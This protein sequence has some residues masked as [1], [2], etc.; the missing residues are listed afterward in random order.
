[1]NPI[2]FPT[3]ETQESARRSR[4]WPRARI[5]LIGFVLAVLVPAAADAAAPDTT[6]HDVIVRPVDN[7]KLTRLPVER[8]RWATAANDLGAVPP[9]LPLGRL[10]LALRRS[11]DRQLAYE[12]FLREQQDPTSANYRHWLTPSEIG[13]RFGASQHDIDLLSGWLQT[14]GLK[15]DAVANNRLRIHFSGRADKVTAAFATELHY[16]QAG[17]EKRMANTT[18]P[19]LPVALADAVRS[20]QGLSAIRFKPLSRVETRRQAAAMPG[21][22]AQPQGT[23]CSG[24]ACTHAIFPADFARIFDLAP[25]QQQ[26]VDGSGQTIAIVGRARVNAPDIENF[27]SLAGLARKQPTVLIPTGG[28]DPGAPATTCSDS[29]T[30]SCS[31]PTDAVKDQGEATLDVQRAGSVAPGAT[32]D[33]IVSADTRSIDGVS[34]AIQY[35]IDTD[36][37]P[38]KILSISFG[39]CEADNSADNAAYIDELFGQAAMEGISVFVASGDGGVAGCAGIDSTPTPNERVSANLLCASGNATCVGGTQFADSVNPAAFWSSSN[40]AGYESALGYIPEGSW[41]EALSR[42]GTP[43]MA[44]SGGGVS[45]YIAT[46]PWQVGIGVPGRQGR[47]TP[48]VSFPAATSEGYFG[49]TAA[50]GGACVVTNQGFNFLSG[51]GTS[52][53]TPSMAGIAALLNQKTGTA[54]ANLNPRLYALAANPANRVFHDATP[55]SSGVANCSVAIPSLCNNSTPG[56]DGVGGGLA[57]YALE[58]GYDRATGLGSIDV[59]NLLA[60]WNV[61]QTVAVNL[62]QRGVSGTWANP[63]TDGQGFVMEVAPDF[64]GS[65]TGFLF[66]GWY[67]YDATAGQRWYTLQ[68]QVGT[69]ASAAIPIYLTQ[70][71]QFD[72][73]LTTSTHP[74]GVATIQLSDCWHGSLAYHFSDGS[75]PDGMIPLIRLLTDVGCSVGSATGGSSKDFLAGTWADVSN[76]GQGFVFDLSPMDNVT[77]PTNVMFAGWYTFARDANQASGPAGQ[78]WYTL[79]TTAATTA[80]TLNDVGIYET[81]GGVFDRHATVSTSHVGTANIVFHSCSSATMSYAFTSGSNAGLSGSLDLTRIITVPAGC[82]L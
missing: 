53:S 27:Q 80:T 44:A 19:Q 12:N 29:G 28:T 18:S 46:P 54:Q 31:E 7:A 57:G 49:C 51:G 39:T 41:N 66:G 22:P 58:T 62:N 2:G 17:A 4:D 5:A 10:G 72:S 16:F 35:A 3:N 69:G 20:V 67:T 74:V 73:G 78:R 30:P 56:P 13:E 25:V 11:P 8:A 6:P 32:I 79:Q 14:Q 70:G 45:T 33:L 43:Q 75:H 50:Q 76:N 40:G 64:Y 71:G 55:S 36:P 63:A 81:T 1:M 59:A 61:P 15:F 21:N 23:N 34:L 38:A 9:D 82:H 68:G 47:Y 37:V 26:G 65:G 77:P 42:S 60:Q 48:D 52:A 24:G